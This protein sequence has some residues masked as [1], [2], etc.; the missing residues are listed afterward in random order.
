MNAFFESTNN[1]KLDNDTSLML[2]SLGSSAFIFSFSA[3][4][5][6]IYKLASN[7]NHVHDDFTPIPA[8]M[9]P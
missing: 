5:F 7:V 8:H 1:T 4:L 3:L 9:T 2:I 6:C